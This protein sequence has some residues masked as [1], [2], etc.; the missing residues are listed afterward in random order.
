MSRPSRSNVKPLL[1]RLLVLAL[2]PVAVFSG[3]GG[4][5]AM[6][7]QRVLVVRVRTPRSAMRLTLELTARSPSTS[8]ARTPLS[9]ERSTCRMDRDAIRP[10]SGYTGAASSLG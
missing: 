4:G 6:L 1:R 7:I 3:C 9:R 8:P 5:V 2:V 10:S